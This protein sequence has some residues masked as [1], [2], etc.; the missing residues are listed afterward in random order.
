MIT[1]LWMIHKQLFYFIRG[2]KFTKAAPSQYVEWALGLISIFLIYLLYFSGK[3]KR[4]IPIMQKIDDRNLE[5]SKWDDIKL[6][7]Q[8]EK[9][10]KRLYFLYHLLIYVLVVYEGIV[11][12]ALKPTQVLAPFITFLNSHSTALTCWLLLDLHPLSSS[13]ACALFVGVRTTLF[14][15]YYDIDYKNLAFTHLQYSIPAPI[16]ILMIGFP[17][18]KNSKL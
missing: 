2:R 16:L 17:K 11:F 7:L 13:I 9:E 3:T 15:L 6:K 1:T 8:I 12:F 4:F 18:I 10:S 14:E 5:L